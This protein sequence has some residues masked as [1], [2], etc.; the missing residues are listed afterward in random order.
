MKNTSILLIVILVIILILGALLYVFYN[1]QGAGETNENANVTVTNVNA[2]AELPEPTLTNQNWEPEETGD[3]AV[4]ASGTFRDVTFQFSSA[5]LVN[6]F[7]EKTAE[8]GKDF[9]VVYFRDIP[10]ANQEDVLTWIGRAVT[11]SDSS[12]AR[13]SVERVRVIT[14]YSDPN[15]TGYFQFTVPESAS[16]FVLHFSYEETNTSVPLGF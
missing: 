15:A 6:A 10:F 9:L 4:D 11:V 3:I 7:Q 12:D 2:V 1:R 5:E 13:Y 14:E 8:A 16:D